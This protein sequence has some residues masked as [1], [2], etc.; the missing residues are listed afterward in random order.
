VVNP[1]PGPDPEKIIP[2]LDPGSSGSKMNLK[3]KQ[4]W[5]TDKI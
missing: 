5:K 2:D 1:D 4:L 3:V